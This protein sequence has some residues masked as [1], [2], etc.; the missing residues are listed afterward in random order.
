VRNEDASCRGGATKC[1]RYPTG[2]GRGGGPGNRN[3][4][5]HGRYGA[6]ALERRRLCAALRRR[7]LVGRALLAALGGA[8]PA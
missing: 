2:R 3:A 1:P 7:A 6:R 4:L 8:P 5:K